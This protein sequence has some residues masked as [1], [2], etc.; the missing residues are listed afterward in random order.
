[1]LVCLLTAVWS[2][3]AIKHNEKVVKWNNIV[4]NLAS[5]NTKRMIPMKLEHELRALDLVRFNTD[6]IH[7]DSIEEQA[8]MNRAF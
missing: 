8:W 6:G 4:R 1:M 2:A 5:R 7:F 3:A